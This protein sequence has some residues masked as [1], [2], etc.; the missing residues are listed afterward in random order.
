M[1]S[2]RSES[3]SASDAIK[4]R[5]R[6]QDTALLLA[7]GLA[8]PLGAAFVLSKVLLPW[9]EPPLYAVQGK[10]LVDGEPVENLH[11]AFHPLDDAKNPFCPVGRTNSQG[12]FHL[13]TR[14]DADGA[15]AG[16]YRVTF[17][18]PDGTID[19]CECPDPLLHDQLR[20][21]YANANQSTRQVSVNSSSNSFWFN[22]SR[23]RTDAPPRR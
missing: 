10:V 2:P 20:G 22:A 4:P 23:P 12:I 11:V 7:L 5:W 3:P 16:E 15:P 18:W 8:L 14:H 9:A 13:T 1:G 17:V 6:R 19:E 21:F